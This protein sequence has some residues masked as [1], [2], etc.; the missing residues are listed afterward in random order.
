MNDRERNSEARRSSSI[1]RGQKELS[2]SAAS[3]PGNART[4]STG[5]GREREAAGRQWRHG[6]AQLRNARRHMDPRLGAPDGDC[7]S[8]PARSAYLGGRRIHSDLTSRGGQP[9]SEWGMRG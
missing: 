2:F 5:E 7:S 3:E 1:E 8:A 4:E 9:A 6:M